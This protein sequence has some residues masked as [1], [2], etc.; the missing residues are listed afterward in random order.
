MIETSEVVIIGGGVA[1]CAVAYYLGLSGIEPTIV[2]RHGVATQASG[3]AV[4]GLNPLQGAGIPGPLGPFA[5]E[6]FQM[7]F[8]LWKDLKEETNLDFQGRTVSSIEVAFQEADLNDMENTLDLFS[9]AKGFDTRWLD[10]REIHDLEPRITPKAIR[11]LYCRGNGA[12][13]SYVYTMALAEAAK[14]RGARF[15]KGK[16][17]GLEHSDGKATGVLLEDGKVSCASVVLAMGPWSRQAEGWLGAYIPVDP[18]KGELLRLRPPGPALAYDLTGG[19]GSLYTKPNGQVWC[20]ATEEWRGFDRHVSESAQRAILERAVQ[21][22]PELTKAPVVMKTACLR[23]VTPDC[24]PIIGRVPGC[25]NVYLATAGG[26][27]GILLSTGMG[28]GI[29]DLITAGDTP[30]PIHAFTPDRFGYPSG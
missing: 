8:N 17:C 6:S 12:L 7:H 27:K 21:L 22:M 15:R 29:A 30:L 25:R 18:L 16:V 26:K 1:G 2:E 9:A 28:K 10:A 4:G 5:W 13:D 14:K 3:Y 24:L 19:G 20:G 11:G 23:P